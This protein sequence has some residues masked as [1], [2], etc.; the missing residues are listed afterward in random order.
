MNSV[1]RCFK[2]PQHELNFHYVIANGSKY[3]TLL[4]QAVLKQVCYSPSSTIFSFL[5]FPKVTLHGP[6]FNISVHPFS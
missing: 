3:L 2:K 1:F 6:Q 4:K 5:E